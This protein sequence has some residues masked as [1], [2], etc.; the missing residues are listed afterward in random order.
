M[1]LKPYNEHFGVIAELLRPFKILEGVGSKQ[2]VVF[3]MDHVV[4]VPESSSQSAPGV[5]VASKML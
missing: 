1:P 5:L 4:G 2:N 3:N